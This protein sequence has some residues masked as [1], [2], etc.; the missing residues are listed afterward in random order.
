M[1]GDV[2]SLLGRLE[3]GN[4]ILQLGLITGVLQVGLCLAIVQ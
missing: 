3:R 1:G 2:V 4:G